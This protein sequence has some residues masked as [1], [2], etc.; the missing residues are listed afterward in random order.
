MQGN[1]KDS[2]R[3]RM[4]IHRRHL[5]DLIFSNTEKSSEKSAREEKDT[6]NQEKDKT[7]NVH[8]IKGKDIISA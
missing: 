7:G 8:K 5:H 2:N 3:Q 4:F 1:L 6:E